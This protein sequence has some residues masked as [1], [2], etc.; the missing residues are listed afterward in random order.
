IGEVKSSYAVFIKFR[1][2]ETINDTLSKRSKSRCCPS[3]HKRRIVAGRSHGKI[4]Y[5]EQENRCSLAEKIS[6]RNF[7]R[8]TKNVNNLNIT[9]RY[10]NLFGFQFKTS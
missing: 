4:W 3:H 9:I 1:K 6:V 10:T 5:C 8:R 2:Y 7:K